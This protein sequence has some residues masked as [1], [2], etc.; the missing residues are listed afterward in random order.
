MRRLIIFALLFVGLHPATGQDS[1]V[2][3]RDPNGQ[4]IVQMPSTPNVSNNIVRSQ[5]G[6]LTPMVS[7]SSDRNKPWG[8]MI[9]VGDFTNRTDN[10][11][12]GNA[13]DSAASGNVQRAARVDVNRSSQL[14]GQVGRV[15][16]FADGQGR[17]FESRIYFVRGRLYQI[18]SILEP[19]PSAEQIAAKQRFFETFHFLKP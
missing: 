11:D 3:F 17:N 15:V 5:K 10:E 6:L 19:S 16:V 13:V 1:W 18:M 2:A 14:D 8:L 7:Y 9:T 4:F 12:F